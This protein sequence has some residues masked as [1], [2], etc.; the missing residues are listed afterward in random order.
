MVARS[1]AGTM[2][3]CEGRGTIEEKRRTETE[4]KTNQTPTPKRGTRNVCPHSPIPNFQSRRWVN[5]PPT[6][7]GEI[8]IL[9]LCKHPCIGIIAF[10]GKCFGVDWRR[11]GDSVDGCGQGEFAE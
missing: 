10:A 11:D 3:G 9:G 8:A 4:R 5:P 7:P 6:S 2:G 1:C